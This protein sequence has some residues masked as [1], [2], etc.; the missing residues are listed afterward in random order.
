MTASKAG[1]PVNRE[2]S[3]SPEHDIS[4]VKVPATPGDPPPCLVA[5]QEFA[6]LE[7]SANDEDD[8]EV[9]GWANLPVSEWPAWAR[10]GTFQETDEGTID[11]LEWAWDARGIAHKQDALMVRV[12]SQEQFLR[13]QM[14]YRG[15][16]PHRLLH[17]MRATLEGSSRVTEPGSSK[18]PRSAEASGLA[19]KP[20]KRDIAEQ[21]RMDAIY[22][23]PFGKECTREQ[24]GS[25]GKSKGKAT[26]K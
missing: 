14:G 6:P 1:L 18:R 7:E 20:R 12:Q 8:G 4:D 22:K 19:A 13:E 9:D 3:S 15:C 17:T 11:E 10:L 5:D 25:K 23:C 16:D 2:P 26:G 21:A 24:K